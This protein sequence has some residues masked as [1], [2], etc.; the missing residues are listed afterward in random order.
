LIVAGTQAVRL[1]MDDFG[2]GY[3]SL[4]YLQKFRFDKIKIDRSF[5]QKLG[6]DPNAAAIIRAVVGLSEA[7]GIATNARALK[8]IARWQCCARMAARRRKGSFLR[9]PYPSTH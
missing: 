5:V 1:V 3:A 8:T 9:R 6:V 2:T 7:L 4:G